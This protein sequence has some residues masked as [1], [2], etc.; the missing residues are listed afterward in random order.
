MKKELSKNKNENGN[1]SYKTMMKKV[2]PKSE[3]QTTSS[4]I[5]EDPTISNKILVN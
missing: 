5:D 3:A 1:E 2:S 4:S